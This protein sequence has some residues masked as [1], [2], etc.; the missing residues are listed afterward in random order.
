[1]IAPGGNVNALTTVVTSRDVDPVPTGSPPRGSN[2]DPLPAA[3]HRLGSMA[4]AAA[5][6]SSMELAVSYQRH[7]WSTSCVSLPIE[8]KAL[9]RYW[10]GAIYS[11]GAASRRGKYPPGL[12]GPWTTDGLGLAAWHGDYTLYVTT[13]TLVDARTWD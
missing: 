1:M 6:N 7:R 9:E 8:L 11:M 13:A 5:A 4:S 2:L 12:W 10:F 3:L